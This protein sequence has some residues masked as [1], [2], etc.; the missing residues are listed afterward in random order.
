MKEWIDE[1]RLDF[2]PEHYIMP[3]GKYIDLVNA[4]DESRYN[5]LL[6]AAMGVISA[7][8]NMG[9]KRGRNY[10]RNRARKM[11]AGI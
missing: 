4:I 7:A 6:D 3:G 2:P 8:Y 9:F 11:R 10:E 1:A 5:G